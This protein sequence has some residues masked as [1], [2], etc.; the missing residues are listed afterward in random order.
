MFFRTKN[1]TN[2][3][4]QGFGDSLKTN[5][6]KYAAL[7][8]V[9]AWKSMTK[10]DSPE[11]LIVNR[12]S[13]AE[14]I[15]NVSWSPPS[16]DQVSKISESGHVDSLIKYAVYRVDSGV[17]PD[18]VTEMEKY[19]N[20]VYVTG[21]TTYQD[22]APPSENGYWYFVTTVSRNNI[23]SDPTS[24]AEGGIVV[25]NDEEPQLV[26]EFQLAQKIPETI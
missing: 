18:E 11:N 4:S 6:Y 25:S 14:Y 17:D 19:Y 7:Q 2:Y 9:M 26:N 22:I 20:L 21:D 5:F 16:A 24:S 15:F 23:E 10:P 13:E 3:S 1:I 8:P 12:D